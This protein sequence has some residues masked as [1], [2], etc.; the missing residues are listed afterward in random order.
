MPRILSIIPLEAAFSTG[1]NTLN[2]SIKKV[3]L[4]SN[5]KLIP[6]IKNLFT[7]IK[8]LKKKL[9]NTVLMV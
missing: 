4:K 2:L 9:K 8:N 7:Y 1:I 5:L 6:P 3:N